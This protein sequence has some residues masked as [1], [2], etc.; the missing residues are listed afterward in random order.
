M[1]K[2][3]PNCYDIIPKPTNDGYILFSCCKCQEVWMNQLKQIKQNESKCPY[4]GEIDT[5]KHYYEHVYQDIFLYYHMISLQNLLALIGV[6]IEIMEHKNEKLKYQIQFV[7][8][9]QP[10]EIQ[11]SEYIEKA[12][13]ELK[14]RV[15]ENTLEIE[16]K[17]TIEVKDIVNIEDYDDVTTPCCTQT[18][19]VKGN[20]KR[21]KHCIYC[22][23]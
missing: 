20:K 15:D 21:I 12:Y 2:I 6:E 7:D 19:K 3:Y 14:K 5:L 1:K 8:V 9:N 10:N 18:L 13:Q 22:N 23:Q 16:S 4:C 17:I 11:I